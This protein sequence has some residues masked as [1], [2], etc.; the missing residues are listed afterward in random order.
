MKKNTMMRIASVLLVVV[1]LTTSVI[2]GTFAKYISTGV[3]S[4][5]A[6]V[7]KWSIE[8]EGTEI[9]VAG[10]T[11]V[12]FDLFSTV[13]DSNG[14]DDET[15]MNPADGTIIAPGTSGSFAIDIE[16]KSEVNAKY[17]IALTESN[18]KNIP[19]QYSVDGT[20]WKD[21]VAELTMDA[22]T[23]QAIAMGTG[24]ATKTVYWRW[25]FEGTT[26]GAH[27]GQTD[28]ADT[29]LGYEG[30]ATVTIQATI[31]VTQVD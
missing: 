16:N 9:G 5:I 4:D 17:T 18:P 24:V 19:L 14:T 13:K 21:S 26:P 3:G 1:L 6:R 20:N 29:A 15:D 11:A 12:A 8:V 27:A 25:V 23:D 7:A 10:D 28:A 31:T 30:T 2:S 22:L